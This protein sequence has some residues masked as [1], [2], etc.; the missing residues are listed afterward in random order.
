MI[1]SFYL[2]RL[3]Y[4]KAWS[5]VCHSSNPQEILSSNHRQ[6]SEQTEQYLS[7]LRTDGGVFIK[8]LNRLSSIYQNSKKIEEYLSKLL[9]DRGVFIKALNR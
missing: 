5:T 9:S 3:Y 7:K 4:F 2:A 6:N 8:T 1:S